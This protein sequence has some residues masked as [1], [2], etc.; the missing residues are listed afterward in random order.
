[1]NST[2][3]P[4]VVLATRNLH[5]VTELRRILAGVA[6]TGVE[7]LGLDEVPD[8]DD[9]PETGATFADNALQKARTV[10]TATGLAAVAD[11]SGLCVDALGG[12]PG[13]LS[14]RWAGAHGDDEANLALVLAQLADI[15]DERRGAA[16]VC[17]AA[18][19][20]PDRRETVVEG[21]LEGW[22]VREPR[23]SN[24][25]GYDPVFLPVASRLTTAQ[26]APADK[27]DI[28]HRGIAFRRLAPHIARLRG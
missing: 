3:R 22:V 21:R 17:A 12:M 2:G 26:M 6:D 14:A 28:S 9:V 24:G 15:P 5:K 10:V 16:F 19:V 7:V 23:G 20:T 25:F 4:R 11:D 8:V 18:L 13:V 27:D 1:M